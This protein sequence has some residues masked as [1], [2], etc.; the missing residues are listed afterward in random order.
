MSAL[1]DQ[2]Q[3]DLELLEAGIIQ[4]LEPLRGTGA[5]GE[6]LAN[7]V[8]YAGDGN[9]QD[10]LFDYLRGLLPG[11]CVLYLGGDFTRKGQGAR[12]DALMLFRVFLVTRTTKDTGG[13]GRRLGAFKLLDGARALL[14]EARIDGAAGEVQ[15]QRESRVLAEPTVHIYAIDLQV[16]GQINVA[17]S[18]EEL[19][20][21]LRLGMSINPADVSHMFQADGYTPAAPPAN[22]G[23]L[24]EIP[25][26]ES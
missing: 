2:G 7:I 5:A 15:L 17:Q 23:G 25:Q 12:Y 14:A 10:E 26:G 6:G 3:L 4:L 20:D 21:F 18:K 1:T 24:T 19:A 9:D 16:P 13:R 22:V 8:G 11:A